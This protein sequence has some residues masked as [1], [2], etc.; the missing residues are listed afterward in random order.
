MIGWVENGDWRRRLPGYRDLRSVF[1][2]YT[3][4]EQLC[5]LTDQHAIPV[6][7]STTRPSVAT[8]ARF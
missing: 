2:Y 6:V 5:T 8:D 7:L 3:D 4:M 1:S